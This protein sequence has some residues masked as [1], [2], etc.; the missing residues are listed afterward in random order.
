MKK[1]FLSILII[2]SLLGGNAYAK[3]IKTVYKNSDS[4]IFKVKKGGSTNWGKDSS[5]ENVNL[6]YV[7]STA[8]QHCKSVSKKMFIFGGSAFNVALQENFF[9]LDE[10]I[11]GLFSFRARFICANS[12]EEAFNIFKNQ[13]NFDSMVDPK[14]DRWTIKYSTSDWKESSFKKIDISNSSNTASSS[15][16]SIST[17]DKIAQS[18]Q[19]CRDLGFKTNNEKFADCALKMMSIQF[20]TTNKVASA[21]GGTTQEVIVTHRNDYDIWDALLDVSFA[22]QANNRSTTSSSSS[23]SGTSCF[24]QTTTGGHTII[25]CD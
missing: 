11:G 5:E 19:I 4:I 16:S 17:D 22:I 14:E 3:S 12:L 8:K 18:K 25:N 21:S 13:K 15:S 20:E 7:T 24:A 1:L 23:N 9:N 10:E 6:N 2:C